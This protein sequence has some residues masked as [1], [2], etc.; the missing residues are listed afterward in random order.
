MTIKRGDLKKGEIYSSKSFINPVDQS[1]MV[2]VG[3]FMVIEEE[4]FA[5]ESLVEILSK[6]GIELKC[7]DKRRI[8]VKL[9]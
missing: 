6:K 2:E 5:N 9:T 1:L 3:P 8:F 4:Q 7:F